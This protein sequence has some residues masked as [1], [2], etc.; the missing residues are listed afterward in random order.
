MSRGY[1]TFPLDPSDE[2]LA[3]DWT[4]TVED[5]VEIRRCRGEDNRH[6]FALQLCAL[7]ALGRFADDCESVPVRVVNH[8]GAQLGLRA[9]LFVKASDRAATDTEHAHR[10]RAHLGY[11][12]FDE[13]AQG[14]LGTLLAER[15][16]DGL[17]AT[18]LL[19]AA[20]EALRA[21][22][23]EVPAKSTI[24]RLTGSFASHA[25]QEAWER[26]N[27]R[28]PGALREA[29]D[30][31]LEV[32]DK[33]R[34]S[35]LQHL[36]QD[37]PEARPRAILAHLDRATFLRSLNLTALDFGGVRPE[38]L[39]T[40][41]GMARRYDVK[42]IRRLRPPAKRYAMVACFLVDAQKTVVDQVIEMHRIYLLTL[43]RHAKRRLLER[44]HQ[45]QRRARSG[46]ATLVQIVRS[47]MADPDKRTIQDAYRDLGEDVVRGAVTA[48]GQLQTIGERGFYDEIRAGHHLL[49][50]YLPA[51]LLLPFRAQPGTEKLL[52]AV[53]LARALHRGDVELGAD[54][55][56]GFASDPWRRAILGDKGVPNTP[57]WE[58][59]LALAVRD[60]LQAGDLYLEESRH[61]VSF[62]NLMHGAETWTE[63]REVAYA[64]LALSTDAD[65]MLSQLRDDL[66]AAA[67]ALD[68]GMD[69]NPFASFV[70]DKLA[71]SKE[72]AL[73]VPRSV[74]DLKRLLETR[75]PRIRLED[76]LVE[77]DSWCGFTRELGPFHGSTPRL[78]NQYP[79]LLAALVAHGTNLGIATMAQSTK[80]VSVDTLQ[81]MSRWYLG[82]D[83][84]KGASRV[85]VDYHHGLPLSKTWGE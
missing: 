6:R 41:A 32:N 40:L 49:K 54:P 64:D 23:T 1:P 48:C 33:E 69:E 70:G 78:E 61:H 83:A 35:M 51:F 11:R 15:A 30:A 8:L 31:M 76:L 44:E 39:A 62:W 5:L 68:G 85:L 28:L 84:L 74:R 57:L 77:V 65:Q 4:L 50:R 60:A 9:T 21:W 55:P 53:D 16:A 72:D 34:V 24:E 43:N 14:R 10:I 27:D 26:V 80:G 37:A 45:A 2:E 67:K 25:E 42:E 47:M 56:M 36:K 13:S 22:K 79:A 38:I 71:V 7:R 3:R 52:E 29:I 59:A 46:L 73:E 19:A 66:D 63:K 58:F 82:E 17:V 75:L 18:P 20:I 81:H 12:T